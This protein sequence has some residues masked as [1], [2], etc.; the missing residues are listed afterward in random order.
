MRINNTNNID[1]QIFIS[2]IMHNYQFSYE[3]AENIYEEKIKDDVEWHCLITIPYLLE[4]VE[5]S[6]FDKQNNYI[7]SVTNYYKQKFANYKP[8]NSHLFDKSLSPENAIKILNIASNYNFDEDSL[9]QFKKL[10]LIVLSDVRKNVFGDYYFNNCDLST[11]HFFK[12]AMWFGLKYLMQVYN[13]YQ[14][15]LF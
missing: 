2:A 15:I 12:S 14:D 10:N 4:E 5:K 11:P 7:N 3:M 8:D 1:K 6:A 9:E 13:S